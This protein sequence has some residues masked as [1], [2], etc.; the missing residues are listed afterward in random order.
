MTS[1]LKVDQIQLVDGSAPTVKD[2][3]IN[4]SGLLRKHYWNKTDA[5]VATTSTSYQNVVSISS[6]PMDTTKYDYVVTF[7]SPVYKGVTGSDGVD[8]SIYVGSTLVSEAG[9]RLFNS[10]IA[11]YANQEIRH[12][13]TSGFVGDYDISGKIASYSG[14]SVSTHDNHSNNTGSSVLVLEF[15]K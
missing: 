13:I 8:M 5:E 4:V 11:I 14:G 15:Y 12:R 3:G 7:L 1:T 6:V 2:L 9:H 10:S